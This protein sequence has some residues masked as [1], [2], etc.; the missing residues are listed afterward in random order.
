MTPARKRRARRSRLLGVVLLVLVLEGAWQITALIYAALAAS[1]L[2]PTD[3][4]AELVVLCVGDSNTFG[5]GVHAQS[6]PSQL[7]ARLAERYRAPVQVVNRGIP[8]SN[9]AQVLDGLRADLTPLEPDVEAIVPDLVLILAGINDAWNS[10][11]PGGK[12]SRAWWR[13]LKLVDFTANLLAGDTTAGHHEPRF[14]T[15]DKGELIVHRGSESFEVNPGTGNL[16]RA[17]SEL[18]AFVQRQLGEVVQASRDA[19]ARAVL[20][21]YAEN[22][23]NFATVN[24]ATREL[25]RE[26]EVLLV[27]HAAVFERAFAEGRYEQLMRTD[28]HPNAAGYAL[29]TDTLITRLDEAGWLPAAG[30]NHA[31]PLARP[32]PAPPELRA[33]PDGQLE[34]RGEAGW[35][36]QLLVGDAAAAG[37]PGLSLGALSVPLR[38]GPSLDFSYAQPA[39]VGRFG[40]EAVQ[41]RL[42]RALFADAQ[43]PL[44][45]VLVLLRDPGD[46]QILSEP[47]AGQSAPLPLDAP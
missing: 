3:P 18:S 21:T 26:L 46:P 32:A 40:H 31:P 4:D 24:Q 13:H 10:A 23:G 37:T 41:L 33:L 35:S 12:R 2:P 25:A 17:G 19:G 15:D 8:G 14:E 36:W 44:T 1:P 28:Q 27:D 30:E 38:H 47:V 20:M 34:L 6:Y 16:L 5:L 39:F 11:D 29:M 7:R 43:G 42:P 9:S 22:R 45:A